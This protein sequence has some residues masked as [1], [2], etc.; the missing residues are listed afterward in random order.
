MAVRYL[1]CT[2]VATT[3]DENDENAITEIL[4]HVGWFC[5]KEQTIKVTD[6]TNY[7]F[8]SAA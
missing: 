3:D 6:I 4:F 8:N 1:L 7:P 2:A 5:L